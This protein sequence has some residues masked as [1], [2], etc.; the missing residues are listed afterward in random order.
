MIKK[1]FF[2]SFITV[3]I[4]L[5]FIGCSTK[6]PSFESTFK[7]YDSK[8]NPKNFEDILKKAKNADVVIFGEGHTDRVAHEVELKLLKALYR[9]IGKNLVFT[10]EMFDR[11]VQTILDEYMKGLISERHF[12]WSAR[13]WG[14]YRR[15]YRPLIEFAKKNKIP[16]K[17]ANAPRRYVNMVARKGKKSL[18]NL[19]ETAKKWIAPL[20]YGKHNPKYIKKIEEL[21][22]QIRKQ[23]PDSKG[24]GFKGISPDAQLT[25]DITMAHSIVRELNRKNRLVFQI[26]GKFHSEENMGI[27]DFL[28]HY[29]KDIK[30]LIITAIEK[31]RTKKEKK[32][33]GSGDFI[34]IT[35]LLEK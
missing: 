29:K 21:N 33:C 22:K 27:P 1:V 18:Y 32:P 7:I 26:N 28:R 23:H 31:R 35:D 34:I 6:K 14:N 30:I 11:D 8:C 4:I 25:W 17:A 15:D 2:K 9:L 3:S 20:P 16:V 24:K 13:A 10:L 19:S 12:R 5:F